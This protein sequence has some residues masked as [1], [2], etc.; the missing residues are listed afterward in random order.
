MMIQTNEMS[1]LVGLLASTLREQ[2]N[3]YVIQELSTRF[4]SLQELMEATEAELMT[5]PG[6]G[7]SKAK[8]IVSAFS[9]AKALSSPPVNRY[10]IRSPEDVYHYVKGEM[11]HL[12][13][14]HFVVLGLNTKNEVIFKD[15]IFI[16]S[17]NAS[18]VHPREVFKPLIKRSCASGIVLH[19]HPS[20]NPE[21]S[22]EDIEV[23]R[24]LVE[25]GRI[26][27]IDILDHI[28]VR[29]SLIV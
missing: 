15:A 27:G 19:N 16:G 22:R 18:I 4:T 10:A 3:S 7:P 11:M 13:Q 9:L 17:L 14:E 26:I 24:R 6:I 20:G 5:I 25:A 28:I 12:T 29:T 8:S 23:T 2:T 21:P 1:T